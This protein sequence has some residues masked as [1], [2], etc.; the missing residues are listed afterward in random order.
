MTHSPLVI[1]VIL[2]W[3]NAPDTLACLASVAQ[4]AYDNYRVVV[5]DNGSQ[6]DSV[7]QVRAAYPDVTLLTLPENLGYAAGNNA[8][9]RWAMD[10][11]ADY[12]FVLNND[13]LLASDML[14]NLVKVI[15]AHPDVGMVGPKMYCIDPKDAIFAAGSVIDWWQGY[16]YHRGMFL[17]D[18]YWQD[19]PSAAPI[20]FITG[21]GVL[22]RRDLIAQAGALDPSYYLNFEDIE[23]CVRARR[24]GFAVWYAPEAVMWH[25]VSATLGL[26]SPAN[27]YYMTR[28]A[29]LFFGRNAPLAWRWV[30]LLRIVWRT[31][32][33]TLT[34]T[35]RK[36][37]HTE[38][39]YRRR[40]AN[41][42]ALRDFFQGKFGQMGADVAAVCYGAGS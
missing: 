40:Q 13:T 42:F 23:W 19:I 31:L 38:T 15:E 1:I 39:Y 37:Y 27:T 26:A 7:A 2:N 32:R 20:D 30:P 36:R 4:L 9:I 10:E 18:T 41:L 21:C 11:A 14:A 6:D 24:H 12:V 25:K 29:L 33:T 34:W 22:V 8:G 35:V 28:N 16:T 5:V 17:H 3:N